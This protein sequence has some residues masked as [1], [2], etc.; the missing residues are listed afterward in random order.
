MVIEQSL[1]EQENE[2]AQSTEN[3]DWYKVETP[4]TAD[5]GFFSV[6]KFC[7][8]I[9]TGGSYKD[10]TDTKTNAKTFRSLD[11]RTCPGGPLS[12]FGRWGQNLSMTFSAVGAANKVD[13]VKATNLRTNESIPLPG[14]GNT[15]RFNG[16]STGFEQASLLKGTA[17]YTLR[18]T[19]GDII[20]Y[21][22]RSNIYTTIVTDSVYLRNSGGMG[23]S[24]RC[25]KDAFWGRQTT[26]RAGPVCKSGEAVKE[27]QSW[28]IHE[29][30]N[31]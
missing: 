25:L 8:K 10:E 27:D 18:Y 28:H 21:R 30:P 26:S 16:T 14:N 9:L 4:L 31:P 22:C 7:I 2:L 11:W 13:S 17:L 20:L 1:T 15:I 19:T 24:V 23:F 5:P 29:K 6:Q 3:H 12:S